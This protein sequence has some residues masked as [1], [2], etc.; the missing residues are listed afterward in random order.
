MD[1]GIQV[2]QVKLQKTTI[3]P[4]HLIHHLLTATADYWSAPNDQPMRATTILQNK[5][6][7]DMVTLINPEKSPARFTP[8]NIAWGLNKITQDLLFTKNF[9]AVYYSWAYKD[10]YI[11]A[12]HTYQ[13][14]RP[15]LSLG[16]NNATISSDNLGATVGAP[17]ASAKTHFKGTPIED[18]IFLILVRKCMI[19][20]WARPPKGNLENDYRELEAISHNERSPDDKYIYKM[21]LLFRSLRIGGRATEYRD[22][23]ADLLIMLELPCALDKWESLD[24]DFLVGDVK[25]AEV[26]IY[27]ET[28]S[29]SLTTNGTSINDIDN[30]DQTA[31]DNGEGVT[32]V[33]IIPVTTSI[34][35]SHAS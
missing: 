4:G 34:P 12:S 16:A 9:R 32:N 17:P 15:G 5:P 1:L 3:P 18:S 35:I 26:S 33:G 8:I 10:A 24:S 7:D 29:G 11:G 30:S 25:I 19:D 27:R 6:F 20:I 22:I 28:L 13:E 23:M 21:D 14:N 31:S 2:K